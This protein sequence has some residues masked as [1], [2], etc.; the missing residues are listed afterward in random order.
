MRLITITTTIIRAISKVFECFVTDYLSALPNPYFID[1]QYR[2]QKGKSTET[3][4]VYYV[5][6]L[7]IAS[8]C[9]W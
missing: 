6:F 2:F 8:E 3:N 4:L 5:D 1:E 9:G 7:S